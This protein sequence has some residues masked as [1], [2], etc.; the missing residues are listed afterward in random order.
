MAKILRE[1]DGN[2]LIVGVFAKKTYCGCVL[3]F[4]DTVTI[5]DSHSHQLL[6]TTVF[7]ELSFL[8]FYKVQAQP[9]VAY[10]KVTNFRTVFIFVHFVLLKKYEI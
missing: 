4:S 7:A 3:A 6:H 8:R 9:V 2:N 5:F 1:N 10:C